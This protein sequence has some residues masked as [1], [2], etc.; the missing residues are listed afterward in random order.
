MGLVAVAPGCRRIPDSLR[1]LRL[2]IDDAG[3]THLDLSAQGSALLDF[4]DSRVE[5]AVDS[6]SYT[7][8][9]GS[10]FT[11]WRVMGSSPPGSTAR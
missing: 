9:P 11:P 6:L 8:E 5:L 7:D 1:S 2:R 10:S 3:T 4:P